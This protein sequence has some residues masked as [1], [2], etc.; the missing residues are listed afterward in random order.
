MLEVLGYRADVA[1]NGLEAI[2]AL[3]RQPYDVL[4]MDIQMPEMDGL[5]ATRLIR[6]EWLSQTQPWIIAMTAHA[7]ASDREEC[8]Q[9]GMNSYISKPID[10]TALRQA[11]CE[12]YLINQ[13]NEAPSY[14]GTSQDNKESGADQA[15][16]VENS[17]EPK[18]DVIDREIIA[19]LREIGGDDAKE[20]IQ[21]LI[22]VYLEDAPV[23][24]KTIEGAANLNDVRTLKQAAHALRSTSVTV[25]ATQLGKLCEAIE[26]RADKQDLQSNL[27]LIFQINQGFSRVEYALKNLMGTL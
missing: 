2:A 3:R 23:R 15:I 9:A 21:E 4:L 7:R 17:S 5:E 8:F 16:F 13:T 19:G 18:F 14:S 22:Q 26:S 25:G 6:R 27:L 20:M 1:C 10:M 24:L 12:C 11:L